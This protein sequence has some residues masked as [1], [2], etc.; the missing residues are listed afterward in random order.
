MGR[1]LE[2]QCAGIEMNSE[3]RMMLKL[4]GGTAPFQVEMGRRRGVKREERI[5]KECNS[6]KSKMSYIGSCGVHHGTAS[7]NPC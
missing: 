6:V 5:C 7:E 4:R 1:S 2:S 3:R